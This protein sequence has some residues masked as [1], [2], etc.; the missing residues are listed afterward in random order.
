MKS[1]QPVGAPSGSS[2]W[3]RRP[4]MHGPSTTTACA[5]LAAVA[6][7]SCGGSSGPSVSQFKDEYKGQQASF[8]KLKLAVVGAI[9]NAPKETNSQIAT[10]FNSVG[11]QVAAEAAALHKLNVPSKY[12]GDLNQL[13]GAFSAV[14]S[15]LKAVASAASAGNASAARTSAEKLVLDVQKLRAQDA[16]LRQAL[17]LPASG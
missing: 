1:G 16:T 10:N 4:E 3:E 5:L 12:K 6:L 14:S 9:T 13:A 8:Q 11:G 17:G 2:F 7:A 15:D